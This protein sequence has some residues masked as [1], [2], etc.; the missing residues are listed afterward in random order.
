MNPCAKCG[1]TLHCFS[2][3]AM[4]CA[5]PQCSNTVN[6]QGLSYKGALEAWNKSNPIP[7]PDPLAIAHEQLAECYELLA[8]IVARHVAGNDI[9]ILA[10]D[11]LTKHRSENNG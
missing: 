10:N 3:H 5:N 8:G 2:Y 7:E 1:S 6:V 11:L 4:H 9:V